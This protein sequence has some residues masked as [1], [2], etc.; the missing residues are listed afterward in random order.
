MLGRIYT[1]LFIFTI[2]ISLWYQ[3][4][5]LNKS[6]I[7]FNAQR[8][9]GNMVLPTITGSNYN[10]VSFQNGLF[11]S[12]FSGKNF[13]YFSNKHFEATE[14]LIYH[15]INDTNKNTLQRDINDDIYIKTDK[16]TG[17]IISAQ[18]DSSQV[19]LTKN[20]L[21]YVILPNI[22]DFNIG[23]NIGQTSD[24][25]IDTLKKTLQTEKPIGA[26]GPSGHIKGIGFYYAFDDG[27]FAIKTNVEGAVKPNEIR[28][29]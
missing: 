26:H 3:R 19:L 20:K 4:I 2:I 11:K 7:E 5:Y 21:K 17:E 8:M 13:V 22:V 29:N 1:F 9:A 15:E 18:P 28:K 16:A 6:A 10:S 25:Y 27:D 23:P 14:N 24:V 12:S